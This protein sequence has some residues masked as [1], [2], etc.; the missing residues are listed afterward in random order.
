[1]NADI[2]HHRQTTAPPPRASAPDDPSVREAAEV[3]QI[4]GVDPEAGLGSA[5]AARRLERDGPNALRSPPPRPAWRRMLAQ[6][7]DPL[8][9]LLLGAIAISLGAWIVESRIGWPIDAIVIAVVVLL[10]AVLGYLQEAKAENAVAALVRLT[11]VTS[12]GLRDAREQRIPSAGLVRGDVLVLGEGDAVGADAR[13]VR[14]AALRIQE[15]SL[16]GESAAVLKDAATWRAAAALGDRHDMVWKGTAVVQGTGRAIVTAT[17]M[18]TE[19]G[20][21]AA[22]LDATEEAPTPL[23]KEVGQIGR[24]LG[25]AVVVIA[26]VVVATILLL[27]EVRDMAD[28]VAVLLLGVYLA[29]GEVRVGLAG[30]L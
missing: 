18:T 12:S 16:T 8:I 1:M 22:L 30:F 13:L 27:S 21:I 23:Q 17:G 24:M 10:N 5:E 26:V 7:A 29:V 19:M 3:A 25:I 2:D 14:A 4:L 20:A 11:A 15:A 6:F 28:V 9:Y